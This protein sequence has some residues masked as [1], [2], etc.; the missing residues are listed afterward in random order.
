MSK[1]DLWVEKFRPV[2]FN[3]IIGLDDKF[4]KLVSDNI[5]HLLFI[6]SP[7]TGKTTLAKAIIEFHK[8]DYIILNASDERGIQTIRDKVK[9]FAMTKST[10]NNIKVVFLDEA[11]Y[12]TNE[13]Q[14]SLR[15]IMESYYKVCRFILTANYSNKI[16]DAI[17]SRCTVYDFSN[18]DKHQIL[19]RLKFIAVEEKITV[20]DDVLKCLIHNVYP[21]IRSMINFLQQCKYNNKEITT[22]DVLKACNCEVTEIFNLLASKKFTVARQLYLDNNIDEVLFVRE[23]YNTLMKSN[24]SSVCKTRVISHLAECLK[25]LP[26]VAIKQILVEDT[27]LKIMS[28]L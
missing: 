27:M 20:P 14:N 6:G 16:I 17:K 28:D 3:D 8:C 4:V 2:I 24:Y 12:L 15:N 10:D 23:F 18:P 9:M 22:D 13:A 25:W 7:G 19:N 26:S 5:P 21:D 11:D 1:N